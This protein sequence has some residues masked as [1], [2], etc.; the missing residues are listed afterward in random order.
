MS[1]FRKQTLNYADAMEKELD[2]ICCRKKY[3]HLAK[4]GGIT[5]N[6]QKEIPCFDIE[7][8]IICTKV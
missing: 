3:F 8:V 5:Q 6:N 7:T 4:E 1:K 2:S